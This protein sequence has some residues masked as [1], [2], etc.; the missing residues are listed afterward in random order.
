MHLH[1][2]SVYK[3]VQYGLQDKLTRAQQ[4]VQDLQQRTLE[5]QQGNEELARKQHLLDRLVNTQE[6]HLCV[7]INQKASSSDNRVVSV[8]DQHCQIADDSF[9]DTHAL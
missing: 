7:L 9:R 2:Y 1:V 5:L 4:D 8:D 6:F 3:S